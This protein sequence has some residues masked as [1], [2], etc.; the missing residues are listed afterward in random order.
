MEDI[1]FRAWDE[2]N[3]QMVEV[4]EINFRTKRI[5][6]GD[7]GSY[8]LYFKEAKLLQFTGIRDKKGNDIYEGDI[9]EVHHYRDDE[10]GCSGTETLLG[11]VTFKNG[12]FVADFEPWG[13]ELDFLLS[14]EIILSNTIMG[15]EFQ[16]PELLEV[17]Q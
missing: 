7:N 10:N 13:Y 14:S 2:E 11:L 5:S 8:V 1:K 4:A 16:N 6:Y 15:N 12:A 9:L 3:E 17:D